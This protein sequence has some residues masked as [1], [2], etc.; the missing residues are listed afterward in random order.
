MDKTTGRVACLAMLCMTLI[1]ICTAQVMGIEGK[2]VAIAAVAAIGG[3][4]VG[5]GAGYVMGKKGTE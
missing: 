4:T 3:M 5:G 1:A 2:D